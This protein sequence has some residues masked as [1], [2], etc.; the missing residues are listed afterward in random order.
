MMRLT[1]KLVLVVLLI[2][3]AGYYYVSSPQRTIDSLTTPQQANNLHLIEQDSAT[4]YAIYRLGQPDAADIGALCQLGVSEIVVM[5]GTALDNEF[6][7]RDQCPELQVIYN[8]D[9]D[10][11]PLSGQWLQYFDNWVARAQAEGRK[12][13]FRCTCGCHRTGRLAAYYQMKYRGLNAKDAWDLAQARGIV[14]HAVDYFS[15]LQQQIVALE[16]YIHGQPCSQGEYCVVQQSPV[17]PAC[18]DPLQGCG[19]PTELL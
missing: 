2:L 11:S 17:Q 12:I 7:Y 19:W 14:M 1:G 16:E 8:H 10:L 3:L 4:G 6:A 18:D 5:A 13:A 9:D 15:S